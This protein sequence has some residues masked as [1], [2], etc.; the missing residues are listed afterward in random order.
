MGDNSEAAS[1]APLVS[2]PSSLIKEALMEWNL[3]YG[4]VIFILR[5]ACLS[6][7]KRNVY[8]L[9]WYTVLQISSQFFL[10]I[11]VFDFSLN[12]LVII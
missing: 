12:F 4:R 3:D 1:P 9:V 6:N 11:F 8:C 5:D 7:T 10:F 2:K